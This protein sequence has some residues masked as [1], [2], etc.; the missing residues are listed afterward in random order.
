VLGSITLTLTPAAAQHEQHNQKLFL[1]GSGALIV[2]F[3]V[4][5]LINMLHLFH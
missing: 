5:T 3:V 2:V 1:L 4:W